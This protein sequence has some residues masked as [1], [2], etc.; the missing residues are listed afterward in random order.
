MTLAGVLS[1]DMLLPRKSVTR[2]HIVAATQIPR[3]EATNKKRLKFTGKSAVPSL[4][5]SPQA[6]CH[7]A[8]RSK[9]RKI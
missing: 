5:G 3:I 4:Y 7:A 8:M 1:G 9:A 6:V 2:K